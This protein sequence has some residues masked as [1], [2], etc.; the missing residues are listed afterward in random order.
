MENEISAL[1]NPSILTK[2]KKVILLNGANIIYRFTFHCIEESHVCEQNI[3][4]QC[5]FKKEKIGE[6][7]KM[8]KLKCIKTNFTSEEACS[9]SVILK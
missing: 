7:L 6:G 1:N 8:H 3:L 5:D 2:F 9:A 4:I